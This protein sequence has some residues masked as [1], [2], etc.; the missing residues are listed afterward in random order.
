M[1]A[2]SACAERT[3]AAKSQLGICLHYYLLV[4]VLS[5]IAT[6]IL[7]QFLS[8]YY[9]LVLILSSTASLIFSMFP[10]ILRFLSSG[11]DILSR[12][13][14]YHEKKKPYPTSVS[15]P[16]DNNMKHYHDKRKPYPTSVSEPEDNNMKPIMRR[17]PAIPLVYQNQKRIMP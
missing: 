16:E 14:L 8:G 5:P 4:L 10:I 13:S 17:K 9:L 2:R 3:C 11:P 15:E 12:Y 7:L 1:H 6:P